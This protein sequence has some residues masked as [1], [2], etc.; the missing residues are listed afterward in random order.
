M[1]QKPRFPNSST[2]TL[3][4]IRLTVFLCTMGPGE[5]QSPRTSS[6]VQLAGVSAAAPTT[7]TTPTNT[8]SHASMNAAQPH[9]SYT[10]PSQAPSVE[11]SSSSRKSNASTRGTACGRS[12]ASNS[13]ISSSSAERF[14]ALRVPL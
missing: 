7:S 14:A 2:A 9:L 10:L 8:F 6:K 13:H 4:Y 5:I 11:P 1:V 12:L 3:G